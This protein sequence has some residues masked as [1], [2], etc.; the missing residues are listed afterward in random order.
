MSHLTEK[1]WIVFTI[2]SFKSIVT[3]IPLCDGD[4]TSILKLENLLK[5]LSSVQKSVPYPLKIFHRWG[6]TLCN[7]DFLRRWLSTNFLRVRRKWRLLMTG[8]C[9]TTETEE[10]SFIGRG[11]RHVFRSSRRILRFPSE[12]RK[13]S[14]R[15]RFQKLKNL[16]TIIGV[17][18]WYW[19]PIVC[20]VRCP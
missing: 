3:W 11:V 18:R 20:G 13:L 19:Y 5:L 14:W 10:W 4:C 12:N 16:K 15:T 1:R 2:S 6:V 8:H 17:I 9:P 7:S